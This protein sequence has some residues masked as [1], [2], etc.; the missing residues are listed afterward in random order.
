MPGPV[1]SLMSTSLAGSLTTLLPRH[2]WSSGDGSD[3][4]AVSDETA[5]NLRLLSSLVRGSTEGKEGD[6]PF[7]LIV[8]LIGADCASDGEDGWDSQWD[9]VLDI[10]TW[11]RGVILG[12][13]S[14]IDLPP[15]NREDGLSAEQQR[16]ASVL[17]SVNQTFTT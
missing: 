14:A 8:Y 3:G 2:L 9:H 16:L 7:W 12:S 6:G 5:P 11:N 15:T 17:V 10:L 4:D 13:E 1:S